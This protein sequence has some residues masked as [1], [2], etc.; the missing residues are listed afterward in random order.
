MRFGNP[1]LLLGLL[2]IAVPIVVH[3]INRQRA[4]RQPFPAIAFLLK[5]NEKLAR[6]LKI[7]QWVLLALRIAVFALLPL[8]MARPAAQCGGEG[9][10]TDG[11]L[12][13]SVVVVID[14]SGSMTAPGR[15]GSLYDRAVARA[16][17]LVRDL[18]A[19]DQAAIVVAS[20]RAEAISGDPTEE[21]RPVLDALEEHAPVQ[22]TSDL[23]SALAVAV[24]LQRASRLPQQRTVV[25]TD[26]RA[27]AWPDEVD[28]EAWAGLGDLRF[29]TLDG[30]DENCAI[31]DLT[32]GR[33]EDAASGTVRFDAAVACEGTAPSRLELGLTLDGAPSAAAVAELTDGRG[34]ATFAVRMESEEPVAVRVA[35]NDASGAT[36]DDQRW[37]AWVPER[38]VR[39]LAVNGDPRA[40]AY[41]D[42]LF[43]LRRAL[44]AGAEQGRDAALEVVP[45][46]GLGAADLGATDVVV[47]ANVASLPAA[48]VSRLEQFV[49]GGGGLLLSAGSQVEAERWNAVFG[50]L[51]PKPVRD[52]KVLV[53][54]DAPDAALL[55]TRLA[56]VDALHPIFRVF[57]LPGGETMQ[58]VLAYQYLLLVPEATSEAR[59]VA[60][61]GDG[62]PALVER[63]V[64]QGRVMLWTTTLDL[65]W[66]DLPI[67]TAYLPLVRRTIDYLARRAGQSGV[68]TGVGAPLTLDVAALGVDRLVIEAPS[69]ARTVL[70]TDGDDVRFAPS[71]LGVHRVAAAV[72][73]TEP[74]P[75]PE[76]TFAVNPAAAEMA[77]ERVDAEQLEAWSEAVRSAGSGD[78]ARGIEAG[79]RPLWPLLLF[80]LLVVMYLETLVSVRRRVWQRVRGWWG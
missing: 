28:A 18:R 55:A 53:D 75:V 10:A 36:V 56:D 6:R 25:L 64:G 40:V 14:D 65:D 1:I 58:N 77:L 45:V 41:N 19:W 9:T 8:A 44:Q 31:T 68:T 74:R 42:E 30:G 76:L 22:G 46:D 47:L 15:G 50:A 78:D 69:G 62:A 3:L 24:D 39:V 66:T 70:P 12:P 4:R 32:W 33:A 67:R 38:R 59:V 2:A 26:G 71:E 79:E 20:T 72:G 11:R 29:E 7:K 52:T 57:R 37:A 21:R 27:S 16:D 5:S 35:L 73:E 13:S 34:V 49:A 48:Q 54:P 80:V 51:L 61:F 60:S 43:Y 63:T 17:D 23:A